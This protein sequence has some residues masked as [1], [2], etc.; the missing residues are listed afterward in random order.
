[1]CAYVTYLPV[2]TVHCPQDNDTEYGIMWP[3]TLPNITSTNN[4]PNGSGMDTMYSNVCIMHH[5]IA[6][7]MYKFYGI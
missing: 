3:P 2:A 1:M 5:Y 6:I 4:C 7:Y